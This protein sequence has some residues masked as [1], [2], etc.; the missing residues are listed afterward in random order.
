MNNII[1]IPKGIYTLLNTYPDFIYEGMQKL[2]SDENNIFMTHEYALYDGVVN[3]DGIGNLF[4]FCTVTHTHD[5]VEN[6]GFVVKRMCSKYGGIQEIY[7]DITQRGDIADC[8]A[9]PINTNAR[10]QAEY[11][12]KFFMV[13]MFQYFIILNMIQK[14]AL[15]D[16]KKYIKVKSEME[17]MIDESPKDQKIINTSKTVNLSQGLK[18]QFVNIYKDTRSYE[19]HTKG[20][21]V[22]GHYRHYK[23]GKTVYIKPFCKGECNIYDKKYSITI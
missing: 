6:I 3:V 7:I 14:I 1:T 2:I 18:I 22:R 5:G 13:G 8:Y 19:R 11:S 4:E 21:N 16:K 10:K 12:E 9:E 15:A 17:R 20:W 23:S